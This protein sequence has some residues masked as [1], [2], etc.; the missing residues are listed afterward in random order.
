MKELHISAVNC[1]LL[2]CHMN[3]DN[4][5]F[6][7]FSYIPPLYFLGQKYQLMFCYTNSRKIWIL[8]TCTTNKKDRR[9]WSQTALCLFTRKFSKKLQSLN[10]RV[11]LKHDFLPKLGMCSSNFVHIVYNYS[12]YSKKI[13]ERSP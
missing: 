1:L 8:K 13:I 9:L 2:V 7:P 5:F 11:T 6:L 12:I 3:L 4:T 10:L